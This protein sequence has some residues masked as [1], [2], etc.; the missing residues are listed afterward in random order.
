MEILTS[1]LVKKYFGLLEELLITRV[2][3]DNYGITDVSNLIMI[4]QAISR[5]PG[6][7]RIPNILNLNRS[8]K[9]TWDD[10]YSLD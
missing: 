1:P 8:V 9:N 4:F 2:F 10:S 5:F 7:M 6:R 3:L